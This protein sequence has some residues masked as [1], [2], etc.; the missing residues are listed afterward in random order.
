[1]PK[2][3]NDIKIIED[4]Y[5]DSVFTII[6]STVIFISSLIIMAAYDYVVALFALLAMLFMVIIPSLS[7]I[8]LQKKQEKYS[9]EF[10]LFTSKLKDILHGFEVIK[11]Y[12]MEAYQENNFANS[13]IL[14]THSKRNVDRLL[15]F[16]EVLSM[17]LGLAIQIGI[18][19]I[20]PYFV[21]NGRITVGTLLALT[22]LST[23]L[24]QPLMLI[25]ESLPK[26]QSTKEIVNSINEI[27]DMEEVFSNTNTIRFNDKIKFSNVSFGY[28]EDKNIL[29][30][31]NLKFIQGKNTLLLVEMVVVNLHL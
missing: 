14:L 3:S 8:P 24:V 31:I 6:E 25:F 29:D 22:R 21:L 11:M 4:N 7:G 10:S 15:A 2:F 18:I 20:S 28:E 26:L 16:T 30:N 27:V 9:F 17:V 12:N 19:I 13:N 1:M 5:L 23:S